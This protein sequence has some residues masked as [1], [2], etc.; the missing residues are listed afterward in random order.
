MRGAPRALALLGHKSAILTL[1]RYGHLF[2]DDLDAWRVLLIL[3][4]TETG[5]R[6]APEATK[7]L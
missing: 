6:T 5:L 2:L 1:D 3:L 7:G 4:R